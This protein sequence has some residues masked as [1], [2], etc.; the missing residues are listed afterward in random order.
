[1]TRMEY[2][3]ELDSHLICLPNEE[4]E[5]AVSFYSEYFE[6]AGTHNEAV[7]IAELGKPFQLAKSIISEQS[8]FSRSEKYLK[9]RDSKPLNGGSGVYTSLKKDKGNDNGTSAHNPQ[10][11]VQIFAGYEEQKEEQDISPYGKHKEQSYNRQSGYQPV[12]NTPDIM[13]KGTPNSGG[14]AESNYSRHTGYNEQPGSHKKRKEMS[15]TSIVLWILFILFIGIPIIL[16]FVLILLA[17][18]TALIF[19]IGGIGVA[20]VALIIAGAIVA[21]AGAFNIFG[22]GFVN[23]FGDIGMGF[24]TSGI[25]FLLFAPCLLFFIKF[26]PWCIKRTFRFSKNG[27]RGGGI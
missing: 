17:I 21:V 14:A 12:D 25:G 5:M 16:P 3:A 15:G 7:V 11:G 2:L 24:I 10:A 13:P 4:R 26:L 20:G 27:K 22:S 19:S 9:Y 18:I 23:G 8:D 6:D 1:M